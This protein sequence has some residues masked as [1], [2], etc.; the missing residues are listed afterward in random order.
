MSWPSITI[1]WSGNLNLE[2]FA[3]ISGIPLVDLSIA[4]EHHLVRGTE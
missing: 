2:V 1:E 3:I 4:Y